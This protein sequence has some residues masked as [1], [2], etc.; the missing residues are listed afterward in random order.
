MFN[1]KGGY[2]MCSN[3]I[4]QKS[5]YDEIAFIKGKRG[6]L[7]PGDVELSPKIELPPKRTSEVKRNFWKTFFSKKVNEKN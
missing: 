1:I 5:Y 3:E 2:R 7:L 4:S 6:L